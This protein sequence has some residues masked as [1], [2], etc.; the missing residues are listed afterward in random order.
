MKL[1][2]NSWHAKINTFVYGWMY[3]DTVDCLCPYFW[4][5]LL[6]ILLTPLWIIGKGVGRL[7]DAIPATNYTLPSVSDKTKN[8]VGLGIAYSLFTLAIMGLT[9]AI[10]YTAF[11]YGI[12]FVLMWVGII[13]LMAGALL[14]L[15]FLIILIKERYD[16]W[17]GDH[18]KKPNLLMEFIRAKKNKHCPLVEWT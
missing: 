3:L 16:D 9:F 10:L 11:M 15:I 6:A 17:R 14:G 2:R 18:P 4:G 13:A 1:N 5:T 7:I 8:R 12:I